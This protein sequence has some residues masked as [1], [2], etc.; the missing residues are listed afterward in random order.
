M[1]IFKYA[2]NEC[3]LVFA[4][5]KI[6]IMAKQKNDNPG[7][8]L[9]VSIELDDGSTM[10]CAVLRIYPASNKKQYIAV[11]PME[12]VDD[13]EGRVFVYGYNVDKDGVPELINIEDDD[14]FD[15]AIDA[16]EEL[17]DEMDFFD[18]VPADADLES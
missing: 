15:I 17:L 14:E 2:S 4:F 10:E 1:Q 9:T 6:V 18:T 16:L 5:S 12:D 13:P 8:D 3:R 7:F 11:Q